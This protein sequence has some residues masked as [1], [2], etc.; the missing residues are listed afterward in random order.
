MTKT[1]ASIASTTSTRPTNTCPA[2]P[3]SN[4][5]QQSLAVQT[6]LSDAPQS[7][8]AAQE[9]PSDTNNH[10]KTVSI[11]TNTEQTWGLEIAWKHHSECRCCFKQKVDY[12][13][14]TANSSVD[15]VELSSCSDEKEH[16]V[17]N[18]FNNDHGHPRHRVAHKWYEE[19]SPCCDSDSD[20]E[21]R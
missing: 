1:T 20:L 13:K 3:E 12:D 7:E 9:G 8:R 4:T 18:S 6:N 14:S 16:P 5:S 15:N 17:S 2:L 11:A 21:R 10:S 19:S